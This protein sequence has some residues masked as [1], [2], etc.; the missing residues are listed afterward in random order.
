MFLG[1]NCEIDSS[2]CEPNPCEADQ[3]CVPHHQQ[4]ACLC[5]GMN[6]LNKLKRGVW[7]GGVCV[8]FSSFFL[9]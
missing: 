1:V 4:A 2:V 7:G 5:Q 8:C 9:F 6:L 3:I